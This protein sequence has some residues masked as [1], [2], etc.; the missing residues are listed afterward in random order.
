MVYSP[1]QL[2]ANGGGLSRGKDSFFL[3]G[4]ATGSLNML[5]WLYGQHKMDF[6]LFFN[7]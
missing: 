5:Q 1:S 3:K 6:F 2:M 4:L 7:L